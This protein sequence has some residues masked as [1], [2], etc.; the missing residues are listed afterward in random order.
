MWDKILFSL[1]LSIVVL[2]PQIVLGDEIIVEDAE[3]VWNLT[4]DDATDVE[5]LVGE[6]GVMVTKYADTFTYYLLE[7]ATDVGR[8]VGEPGVMV[9]KYADT[10]TYYLLE[11]ATDVGRLVGEPGVMVTK[12]ADTFTYYPLEDATEVNHLVGEPGVMVTKYADI[13][14]YS[15]LISP[16]FDFTKPMISDVRVT[17][18]TLTSATVNWVT[19]RVADSRVKYGTESGNYTLQKYDSANVTAHSLNLID[20]LPNTTYYFVVHSRALNGNS[21]E[22]AE[23]IF[24]TNISEDNT[25]PY[26]S[27]HD[28]AKGAMDVPVGTNVV[29]HVLDDE[30]EVDLSTIVMTVEGEVVTPAITGTPADYTLTYDPQV[31]FEYEQMVNVTIDASDVAGNTMNQDAYSFTTV[32]KGPQYF[33]TREGTYPSIRGTHN[34]TITPSI[35]ITVNTLYTYS[36]SGTGG[37]TEYV[38]IHNATETLATGNWE[39]YKSGDYQNITFPEQFTLIGGQT[40]NY[41]IRTGSYPQIIHAPSKEVTGGAITCTKFIDAN[42]HIYDNWIPA[43]RLEYKNGN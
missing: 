24:S 26:T 22:S 15:D 39:G 28:P 43:I 33:D 6:P 31:D 36:C 35:D 23:Y 16:P 19:D 34:G 37:H 25:P 8:L 30:S 41:T 12:Y 5:P 32:S 40:Y 3:T 17:S 9:T 27:G 1:V 42:G 10:F 38:R 20:L 13:F 21:K 29:V 4:L 7:N 2:C 14:S 18:I 11:N